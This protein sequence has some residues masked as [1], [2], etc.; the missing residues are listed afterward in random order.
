MNG[1]SGLDSGV[2][3]LCRLVED[4]PLLP[5]LPALDALHTALGRQ[6]RGTIPE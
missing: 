1:D 4:L 5:L 3:A 6:V 2:T